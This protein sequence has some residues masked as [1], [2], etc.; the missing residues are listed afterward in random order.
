[1]NFIVIGAGN[2]GSGIAQN[3]LEDGHE[4]EIADKSRES[5]N[6]I[7]GRNPKIRTREFDVMDRSAYRMLNDYDASVSALPGS[8]GMQFLKNV[9]KMGKI[10]VDVSYMEEDP[11]DLNG[12]AQSAGTIIVPDMGFAPGLT[13][14]IVGYFSADLDQIRN[15]KI[16]VG[17]IPEKPVPPLDYTITWS[18]EG[19]IDEY[20]RP[21]RIVRNGTEDHVPALSG[22]ERIGV[23]NYADMEAFYT[24]GLRS[25]IRNIKCTGE[26]F[27]KTIR[28]PGHAEKMA[29]IRDL[30][31][32]DRIKV[33]GCNLTMFEI[34]EQIFMEKLFR[35]DIQDVVLMKVEVS[36]TKLGREVTRTAEM[37]TGY[38]SS[39]KRTAM[40]MAT[41]L[42]AS[43]T[44]EFLSSNGK[45]TSGIV[46]PEIL[47]KTQNY[48]EYLVN[49]MKKKGINVNISVK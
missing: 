29:A 43:I 1:M 8:I 12:I 48:F 3:L 7:R 11:Y 36:G 5:L 39:R 28:Y 42:P 33:D 26:M 20:T 23:G 22:I 31:Y 25:L 46:F 27:E 34:S 40:D 38:D 15:V 9:A 24:D 19:L 35:P 44:A 6:R 21:V 45:I 14:A 47:G 18:V 2:I 32:F 17:G 4:V 37:Q 30:G 49:N 10:V 13:N 41:S 16:Y